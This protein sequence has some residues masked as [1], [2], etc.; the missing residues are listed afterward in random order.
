M[1]S[2]EAN[3]LMVVLAP[4]AAAT[5]WNT[6]GYSGTF[7]AKIANTSPEPN[8]R[9]PSPAATARVIPASW[10]YVTVRPLGPSIQRRL[11]PEL[12]GTLKDEVRERG[13]GHIDRGE[14]AA[15]VHH[16]VSFIG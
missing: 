13:I 12:L 5:P 1:S 11:V 2:T 7:G 15:E 6:A 9:A 4:P 3:E 10:A 14:R 8:P 16:G